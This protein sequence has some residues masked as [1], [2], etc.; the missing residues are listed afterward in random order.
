[1]H[2][3]NKI[4]GLRPLS[5]PVTPLFWRSCTIHRRNSFVS[6]IPQIGRSLTHLFTRLCD[7]DMGEG[8]RL[9]LTAGHTIRMATKLPTVAIRPHS[10]LF[11]LHSPPRIAGERYAGPAAESTRRKHANNEVGIQLGSDALGSNISTSADCAASRSTASRRTGA[12]S[13]GGDRRAGAG[14]AF[15]A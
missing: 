3:S 14:D 13:Y 5:T 10:K 15:R 2:N 9:F 8:G 12:A 7:L 1:M 4:G 6:K 11:S